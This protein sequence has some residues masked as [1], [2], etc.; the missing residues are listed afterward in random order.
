MGHQLRQRAVFCLTLDVSVFSSFPPHPKSSLSRFGVSLVL[1]SGSVYTLSFCMLNSFLAYKAVML[2]SGLW[3]LMES[4]VNRIGI[5]ALYPRNSSPV[6]RKEAVFW[7]KMGLSWDTSS[8][9]SL[10]LDSSAFGT[11][12]NKFLMCIPHLGYGILPNNEN[13]QRYLV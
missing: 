9:C 3:G 5:G 10:I 6:K 2:G 11:V 8:N 13:I 4:R 1:Q 12:G 7:T